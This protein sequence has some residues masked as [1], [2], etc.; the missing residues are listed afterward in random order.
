MLAVRPWE[1]LG[2][3][4]ETRVDELLPR[5]DPAAPWRERVRAALYSLHRFLTADERAA[6]L[7]L[8]ELAGAAADADPPVAERWTEY[9]FDLIDEGRE[10]PT[11][12]AGL[13]RMTAEALGGG[14][15]TRLYAAVVRD[16][17]LPD[18]AEIVPE[19][20]Y[21][22]VLPYCGRDA[23]REELEISPPATPR[24]LAL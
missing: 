10:Q 22:V 1:A 24:P 15:C 17:R 20:M 18:E 13:A 7:L 8:A 23:A 3:A 11:A 19:L 4:M 9:L 6:D 5:L 16:G 14:I 12:P 2:F 21:C